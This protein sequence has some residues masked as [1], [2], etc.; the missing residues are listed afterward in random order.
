[1]CAAVSSA[2]D[3]KN[4]AWDDQPLQQ[5]REAGSQPRKDRHRRGI[6]P[7]ASDLDIQ[8]FAENGVSGAE[9]IAAST[10]R[11]PNSGRRKALA[12]AIAAANVIV[13][14]RMSP[15]VQ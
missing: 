6:G 3:G 1:V 13:V 12:I 2:N 10:M 11:Q 4:K 7:A 8:P 14:I 15:P 9:M 5:R